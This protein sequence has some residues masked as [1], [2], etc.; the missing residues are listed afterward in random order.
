MIWTSDASAYVELP[1]SALQADTFDFLTVGL[2]LE[3]TSET[4]TAMKVDNEGG[5][6]YASLC[7]AGTSGLDTC[8][9]ALNRKTFRLQFSGVY[10]VAES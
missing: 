1:F 2:V 3:A 10:R 6:A 9:W 4:P 7:Y 5:T 8:T